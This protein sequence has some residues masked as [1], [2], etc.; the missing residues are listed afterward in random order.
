MIND[1]PACLRLAQSAC[2]FDITAL[3]LSLALHESIAN[4]YQVINGFCGARLES[5]MCY[6]VK[7]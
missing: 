7:T 2:V 4:M 3:L 5:A 6:R 1:L